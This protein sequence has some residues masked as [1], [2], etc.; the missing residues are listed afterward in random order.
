MSAP[1]SYEVMVR[2]VTPRTIA[3]VRARVAIGGVAA[4]FRQH[5]DRVYAAGKAGVVSLDG[6]NV[7][8]YH[9]VPGVPDH[10][11]VD[12]GVGATRAFDMAAG[13]SCTTVPGG[14]VVTTT[15][16]GDYG[17]LR[18]AHNAVQDWIRQHAVRFT[19]TS[20]EVYGHWPTGP[21]APRTDIFYLIG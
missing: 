10:L 6:Q 5:L 16:W 18:P 15:H 13:I 7:F 8:V 17:R 1:N 2:E 12:F 21:E 9:Q 4:V 20:W 19:G 11:D 3:S 14:R